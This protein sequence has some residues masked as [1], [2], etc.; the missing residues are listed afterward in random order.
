MNNMD[1]LAKLRDIHLPGEVSWW[2]LAPLWWGL[3]ILVL[4]L[5]IWFAYSQYRKYQKAA[6]L[7]EVREL[8]D[9]IES[10]YN[11]HSDAKRLV[12][13]Y[14]QLLRR[15]VI[16]HQGRK[17]GAAVTGTDWLALLLEYTQDSSEETQMLTLFTEGVYQATIE[18]RDPLLVHRWVRQCSEAICAD[19]I[20]G[21][22][23]A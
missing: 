20:N 13:D 21:A 17:N 8:L 16:Q 2:P 12:V 19:I 18:I 3:I 6:I 10:D 9:S 4:G 5:L 14:S 22:H 15:L 7:R 11:Q 23:H 1:P